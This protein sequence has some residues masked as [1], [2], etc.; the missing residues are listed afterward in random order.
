MVEDV[1]E[2]SVMTIVLVIFGMLSN[3]FIAAQIP[4]SEISV[5]IFEEE[6]ISEG[7]LAQP[8]TSSSEMEDE[9]LSGFEWWKFPHY[10]D[11]LWW[12]TAVSC[13]T[14]IGILI[15]LVAYRYIQR[16]VSFRKPEE[17]LCPQPSMLS[18]PDRKESTLLGTATKELKGKLKNDRVQLEE[19]KNCKV[20]AE[21]KSKFSPH[22]SNE[23]NLKETVLKRK[24]KRLGQ[25]LNIK[26]RLVVVDGVGEKVAESKVEG[27]TNKIKA[28]SLNLPRKEPIAGNGKQIRLHTN[29]NRPKE[30]LSCAPKIAGKRN[31][32]GLHLEPYPDFKSVGPKVLC[33][34]NPI[35]K[36]GVKTLITIHNY[37]P[38]YKNVEPKVRTWRYQCIQGQSDNRP[39]DRVDVL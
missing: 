8:A 30:S 36:Q 19:R 26:D 11:E 1:W 38:D 14:T 31:N 18:P 5:E 28:K 34:N 21:D 6:E 17:N 29:L 2:T 22:K 3:N 23:V 12:N 33:W 37:Q 35:Q 25:N 16:Q 13:V 20:K 10:D 39:T 7:T 15:Y 27:N 9:A 32:L 4:G 24:K